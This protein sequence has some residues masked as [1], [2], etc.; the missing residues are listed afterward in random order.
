MNRFDAPTAIRV[1][2]KLEQIAKNIGKSL[3]G[4][5]QHELEVHQTFQT[6]VGQLNDV[7]SKLSKDLYLSQQQSARQSNDLV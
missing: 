6:A 4:E 7:V 3:E 2:E 1:I 5:D